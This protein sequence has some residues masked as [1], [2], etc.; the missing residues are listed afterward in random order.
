MEAKELY[1]KI[2]E[3]S[4]EVRKA[5]DGFLMI[6]KEIEK[7]TPEYETVVELAS[8]ITDIKVELDTTGIIVDSTGALAK[9]QPFDNITKFFKNEAPKA[10]SSIKENLGDEEKFKEPIKKLEKCI[11]RVNDALERINKHLKPSK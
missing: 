3:A 4:G 7:E 9:D 1:T 6:L 2:E 11:I 10:I 5:I 8:K